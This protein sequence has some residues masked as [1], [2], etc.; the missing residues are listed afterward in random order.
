[1]GCHYHS[2]SPRLGKPCSDIV[3]LRLRRRNPVRGDSAVV[4]GGDTVSLIEFKATQRLC[5]VVRWHYHTRRGKSRRPCTHSK[6]GE[7]SRIESTSVRFA[8]EEVV[9]RDRAWA[10][11]PCSRRVEREFGPIGHCHFD[12]HQQC[13]TPIRASH[14][15]WPYHRTSIDLRVQTRYNHKEQM[16]LS[17]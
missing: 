5:V 12:S 16:T 13:A 8:M 11:F 14:L 1:L 6:W 7:E 10:R 2:S 15:R 9:P 3:H 4:P 17:R